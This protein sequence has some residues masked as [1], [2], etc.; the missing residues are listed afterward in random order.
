MPATDTPGWICKQAIVA[1]VKALALDGI[2]DNVVSQIAP[3]S[4]TISYPVV[5]VVSLGLPAAEQGGTTEKFDTEF[6]FNVWIADRDWRH[7]HDQEA[8]YLDWRQRIYL[9]L[10]GLYLPRPAGANWAA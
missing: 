9:A 10:E 2:G 7:Q 8:K 4:N 6:N 1:A 3:D 5:L